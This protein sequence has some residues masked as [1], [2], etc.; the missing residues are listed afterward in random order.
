M[1]DACAKP[2][3]G[4][5]LGNVMHVGN[6]DECLGVQEKEIQGKYCTTLVKPHPEFASKEVKDF[7]AQFTVRICNM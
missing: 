5:L 4:I 7:F 3:A 6:F 2:Q 1:I